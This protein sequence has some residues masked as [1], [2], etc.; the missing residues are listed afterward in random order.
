[1]T[2]VANGGVSAREAIGGF[3]GVRAWRLVVG[4]ALA[5][6]VVLCGSVSALGAVSWR[7]EALSNTAV[8]PGGQLVYHL[9]L[10]DT[11]E[12]PSD[13]SPVNLTVTLPPGLTGVSSDGF[14]SCPT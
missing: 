5:A 4:A 7:L 8:Q 1:M 14:L 13:G 12:D 10:T 9:E 6:M 11:G 2:A 3:V